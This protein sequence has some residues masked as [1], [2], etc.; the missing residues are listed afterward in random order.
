M[1]LSE[2]LSG[3]EGH[4]M[5]ES[6]KIRSQQMRVIAGY[7]TMLLAI[8]WMTIVTVD[9]ASPHETFGLFHGSYSKNI[10]SN[11]LSENG[12]TYFPNTPKG[13]FIFSL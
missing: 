7:A 6:R 2:N 9:L 5:S 10:R 4:E 3:K 8:P 1:I 11:L 12:N 13:V